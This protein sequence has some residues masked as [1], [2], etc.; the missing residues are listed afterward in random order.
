MDKRGTATAHFHGDL[1][2]MPGKRGHDRPDTVDRCRWWRYE[3][4]G[5]DTLLVEQWGNEYRVLR[6][7]HLTDGMLELIPGS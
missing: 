1:G 7:Q 6:G 2:N 5:D 3:S 4:A